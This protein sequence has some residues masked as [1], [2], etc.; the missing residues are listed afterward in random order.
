[1][2]ADDV[3]FAIPSKD[4][5]GMHQRIS[6]DAE[7]GTRNSKLTER[8]KNSLGAAKHWTVV[9]CQRDTLFRAWAM[10]QRH[11]QIGTGRHQERIAE[12][13]KHRRSQPLERRIHHSNITPPVYSV[14]LAL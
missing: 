3:A 11:A 6:A 4:D 7:E 14:G 5:L 1:V 12:R 2:R 10:S 9:K 8:I 13:I